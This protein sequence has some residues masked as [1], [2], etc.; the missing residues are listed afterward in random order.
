MSFSE[1][2]VPEPGIRGRALGLGATLVVLSFLGL[3]VSAAPA[4]AASRAFTVSPSSPRVGQR[5][6]FRTTTCTKA[7]CRYQWQN[8]PKRGPV[9]PLHKARFLTSPK[10]THVFRS[11]GTQYI[12][13]RKKSL[14]RSWTPWR[15]INGATGRKRAR[16]ISV[17][18]AGNV[19]AGRPGPQPGAG[20]TPGGAP[21]SRARW[22]PQAGLTW[23]WQ[24]FGT[25]N[26]DRNAQAYDVDPASFPGQDIAGNLHARG[27]RA[28]CYVN[29]GATESFRNDLGGVPASA[30]GA[31]LA[32]WPGEFWLDVRDASVRSVM[33]AR[34][35]TCAALGFDAVEPDNMDGYANNSGLPLTAADQLDYNLWIAA[36]VH[37]L[38]MAVFQKNDA[39]QVSNLQPSFDGAIVEQ[40]NQTGE[41]GSYSPYISAGKPVLNAEYTD[42]TAYCAANAAQGIRTAQFGPILDG[43]TFVPC[44]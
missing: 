27:K 8:R 41:C 12:A 17:R 36:Q 25:M 19:Q 22:I 1:T 28:I 5:V 15:Y 20:T 43:T 42:P 13:V 39:G 24:L 30:K 16:G 4:S 29:V 18:R 7:P 31:E 2:A 26:Y 38:G 44:W 21:G 35:Q 34:F 23:Y 33:A 40:C 6:T 32:D 3:A 10:L 14:G 9:T 11:R 37:G